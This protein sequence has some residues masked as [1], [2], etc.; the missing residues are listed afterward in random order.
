MKRLIATLVACMLISACTTTHTQVMANPVKPAAGARILVVDPD[1]QLGL[2][3]ASGMTEPK[4][5]W[6]EQARAN[7]AAQLES[8]MKARAHAYRLLD[9][10]DAMGGRSGQ[11]MRLHGAVSASI[12]G[13]GYALPTKKGAFD[14]TLGEG[15]QALGAAQSADYALFVRGVGSY[16]SGGR[17]A[18]A[19]GMAM[20]GVSV[21]L[22]SQQCFVTL[23]DL[24]TGR[25]VWANFTIA[26][27]NADMRETAGASALVKALLKDAPL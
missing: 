19:V 24:K 1:I 2:L 15:A 23:V 5:D 25:V 10:D 9:P 17:V 21:P 7:I 3:T 18:T 11:L 14:W 22:G 6:T 16:A 27:P 8:E 20:L 12:Q 26:G 4:A 13:Y